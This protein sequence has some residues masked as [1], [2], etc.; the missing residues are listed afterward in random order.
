MDKLERAR[1][2]VDHVLGLDPRFSR[3]GPPRSA[4]TKAASRLITD[5]P[6]WEARI[7]PGYQK[8]PDGEV[9]DLFELFVYGQ[10]R[11]T[12]ALNGDQIDLRYFIPGKWEPIFTS[13]DSP[14]TTPLFPN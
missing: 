12:A 10:A 2:V 6:R 5:D 14:D 11:M 7:S 4:A 1:I 13:F 3:H 9:W 8:A